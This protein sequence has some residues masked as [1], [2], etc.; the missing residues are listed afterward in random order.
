[1][2]IKKR[3]PVYLYTGKDGCLLEWDGNIEAYGI[4]SLHRNQ[5]VGQQVFFLNDFLPLDHGSLFF[6]CVKPGAQI[7]TDIHIFH[8][9]DGD[10][11]LLL[12]ATEEEL[13]QKRVQ[14]KGNEIRL[15]RKELERMLEGAN[16][17][18]QKEKTGLSLPGMFR[19]MGEFRDVAVL[20]ADICQFTNYSETESPEVMLK[21]LNDFIDVMVHTIGDGGGFLDK[22]IGDAVMGIFGLLPTTDAAANLAVK[23]SVTMHVNIAELNTLRRSAELPCFDI[24]IGIASGPVAVGSIGVINRKMISAIGRPV[25]IA[26]SLQKQARPREILIDTVTFQNISEDRSRF[27]KIIKSKDNHESLTAFSYKAPL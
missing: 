16:K 7:S 23:A 17:Y 21:T 14:Q 2:T 20:F 12:D 1:M 26:A 18:S 10:W 24:S 6:P 22:V 15:L 25:N 4:K 9:D 5:P 11:T 8:T 3:S 27:S 13:R 19:E